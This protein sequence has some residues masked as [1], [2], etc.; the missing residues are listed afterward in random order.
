MYSEHNRE[1]GA[2]VIP[3]CVA[4][5]CGILQKPDVLE[6]GNGG[7]GVLLGI[8]DTFHQSLL[9]DTNENTQDHTQHSLWDYF[10][11]RFSPSQ[12][13]GG[14]TNDNGGVGI[15]TSRYFHIDGRIAQ[16]PSVPSCRENQQRKC[17]QG[18]LSCYFNLGG[19]HLNISYYRIVKT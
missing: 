6:I 18:V 5:L 8:F 4:Q 14:G 3:V 15:I 9:W 11:T 12:E 10:S 16:R 17:S 7:G 13:A 2:Y 1:R 19:A